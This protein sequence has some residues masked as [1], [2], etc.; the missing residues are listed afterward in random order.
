MKKRAIAHAT[1]LFGAFAE[2]LCDER[3]QQKASHCKRGLF[4][5]TNRICKERSDGIGIVMRSIDP[6]TLFHRPVSGVTQKGLP[7]GSPHGGATNR[8]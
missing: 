2:E 7:S 3:Q 4:V 1:A 6:V 5:V 8:I